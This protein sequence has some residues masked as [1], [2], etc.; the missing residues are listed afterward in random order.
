MDLE[1]ENTVKGYLTA[2][3]L[4][5]RPSYTVQPHLPGNS[6]T[7]SGLDINIEVPREKQTSGHICDIFSRLDYLSRE[8]L[9]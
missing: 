4:P 9:S 3:S 1:A 5:Y 7:L 8:D 2:C 6:N